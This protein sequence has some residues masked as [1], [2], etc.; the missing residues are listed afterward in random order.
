VTDVHPAAGRAAEALVYRV[1]W[2]PG[3]DELVGRCHCGAETRAEDPVLM[4][5][6]LI[7][8]PD[9]GM[10]DALPSAEEAV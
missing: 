7:A 3:S 9:H 6:W 5:Q 10:S 2:M 8:H 4:W 1:R